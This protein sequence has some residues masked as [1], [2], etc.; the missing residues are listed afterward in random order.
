MNS[1]QVK[2][3][4]FP[5]LPRSRRRREA[6]VSG[7]TWV[8]ISSTGAG[9]SPE[10]RESLEEL[11]SWFGKDADGNIY[12][13]KDEQGNARGFYAYGEITAGGIGP[14]GGGGSNV[15]W[16]QILTTGTPI[17]RITI[18]NQTPITVYAPAGGG[19]ASYLYQLEDIYHSGQTILRS[20]GTARQNG[21]AIVYNSA[22]NKWVA[23][24]IPAISGNDNSS[25]PKNLTYVA[26]SGYPYGERIYS[27]GFCVPNNAG[28]SDGNIGVI[29]MGWKYAPYYHDILWSPNTSD[30]WHR[31][32][33]TAS[34]PWRKFWDSVNLTD[35]SQLA[36]GAGYVTSSG[37]VANVDTLTPLQNFSGDVDTLTNYISAGKL[38]GATH[39]APDI[40]YYS[41]LSW[42][43]G[44]YS[45]QINAWGDRFYMRASAEDG[46]H[47]WRLLYHS[48]NL[49]NPFHNFGGQ[50]IDFNFADGSDDKSG[51]YYCHDQW[52]QY[53]KPGTYGQILSFNIDAAHLQIYNYGTDLRFR[54]RWWSL[55]YDWSDWLDIYHSGNANREDTPWTCSKLFSAGE[56]SYNDKE[57]ILSRGRAWIGQ[58]TNGTAVIDAFSGV[59]RFGCDDYGNG[60]NAAYIAIKGSNGKVGIGTTSPSEK[61]DISGNASV[62]TISGGGYVSLKGGARLYHGL[63][64]A[65]IISSN[66]SST[67]LALYTDH[68]LRIWAEDGIMAYN[69]IVCAGEITAGAASDARFKDNQSDLRN[70]DRVLKAL[71]PVEF[72]WNELYHSLGGRNE[73]HDVGFLAQEV[74][75][76]IPSAIDRIYGD[77]LRLDYNKVTPYLVAGWQ[78]HETEIAR[79][80]RRVAELEKQLNIN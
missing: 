50:N 24:V 14:G 48:G 40:L 31:S 2:T 15:T 74:Q 20:D 22:Q 69:N 73:G 9:I 6:G 79:L 38:F 75:G 11:L 43:F 56:G 18:D 78:M 80:R 68:T 57:G 36:N 53:N 17:A 58:N 39:A 12:V 8:A 26:G 10:L 51:I 23:G 27:D 67:D 1:Y 60:A 3:R 49:L 65:N 13:K 71:R 19:G 21:D 33:A 54:G 5:A 35:N 44:G 70:A 32:A 76:L 46:W 47:D 66:F 29:R 25:G 37:S 28:I 7:G 62:G 61:L 34:S 64:T 52:T 72:E 16:E 59:A 55:K 41:F 4:T 30:V 63:F 42:G 45:A 77:Y